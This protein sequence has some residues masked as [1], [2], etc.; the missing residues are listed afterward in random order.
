[1]HPNNSAGVI[2]APWLFSLPI[3][4]WNRQNRLCDSHRQLGWPTQS[5]QSIHILNGPIDEDPWSWRL[6]SSQWRD[7]RTAASC[8][9]QPCCGIGKKKKRS[10]P[11]DLKQKTHTNQTSVYI[12]IYYIR[13]YILWLY[14]LYPYTSSLQY[15]FLCPVVEDSFLQCSKELIILQLAWN[16]GTFIDHSLLSSFDAGGP[17]ENQLDIPG[18]NQDRWSRTFQSCWFREWI[19]PKFFEVPD[20]T[21]TQLLGPGKSFFPLDMVHLAI[22]DPLSSFAKLWNRHVPTIPYHWKKTP[23][24]QPNKS[25]WITEHTKSLPKHAVPFLKS[26]S[27]IHRFPHDLMAL[28]WRSHTP[29]LDYTY[30]G[31]S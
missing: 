3:L 16:I 2:L 23:S 21:H 19:I 10:K 29:G 17:G 4:G 7:K 27:R 13:D 1:M 26:T 9:D 24:N 25:K 18:M 28:T 12:Y 20:V 5:L 14:Q 11:E 15:H 30:H 6:Q 22:R 8:Q 31:T